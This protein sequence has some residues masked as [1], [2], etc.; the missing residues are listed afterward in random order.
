MKDGTR[1]STVGWRRSAIPLT[2]RSAGH[3]CG[4]ALPR[5]GDVLYLLTRAF[6]SSHAQLR[7]QSPVG[8]GPSRA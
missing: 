8:S 5:G 2:I 1:T 3:P 7:G 6:R 4:V